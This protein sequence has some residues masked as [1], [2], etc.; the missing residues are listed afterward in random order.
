MQ[1]TDYK[2]P[3]KFELQDEDGVSIRRFH[4]RIQA[5]RFLTEG[6]KLIRLKI[7]PPPSDYSIA[8]SFCGES[9]F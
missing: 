8:L 1:I 4:S 2:I 3:H 9:P 5:E 6:Y 7:T